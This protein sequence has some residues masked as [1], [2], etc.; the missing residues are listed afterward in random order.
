MSSFAI[1]FGPVTTNQK[2]WMVEQFF[3]GVVVNDRLTYR[4]VSCND[5][6]IVRNK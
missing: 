3:K 1:K 4:G 6:L 5:N 2:P